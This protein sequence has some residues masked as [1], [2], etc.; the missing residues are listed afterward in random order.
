MGASLQQPASGV[1]PPGR[2]LRRGLGL[3]SPGVL[4]EGPW[5]APRSLPGSVHRPG[6]FLC[7]ARGRIRS[8]PC[9]SNVM[10]GVSGTGHPTAYHQMTRCVPG[11]EAPSVPVATSS[12]STPPP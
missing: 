4:L 5:D 10:G 2:V 8:S 1:H 12:E 6:S 11:G 3:S 9:L 7:V